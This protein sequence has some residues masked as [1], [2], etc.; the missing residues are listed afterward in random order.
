MIEL[1]GT[2]GIPVNKLSKK[3]VGKIGHYGNSKMVYLVF[4]DGLS[5]EIRLVSLD[6]I[7]TISRDF[8]G[9]FIEI[10]DESE[11]IYRRKS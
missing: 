3:D 1:K 4:M 6:G 11:F 10:N 9:N 7:K 5:G 8:V 2:R